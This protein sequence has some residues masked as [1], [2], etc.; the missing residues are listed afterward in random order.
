MRRWGIDRAMSRPVHS[1]STVNGGAGSGPRAPASAGSVT[2]TREL[3]CESWSGYFDA[4]GRELLSAPVS[5]EIVG[6]PGP[7][8]L[9]ASSLAL[10]ALTADCR[11]RSRSRHAVP[12][13]PG[14]LRHTVEHPQCVCMD[15][16]T[17]LASF[18]IAVDGLDD[19]RTVIA[20]EH[21]PEAGS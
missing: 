11:S 15:S 13:L 18:T 8:I 4:V 19:V 3:A 17:M 14:V 12:H 1:I 5:I 20:I 2:G 9:Q 6:A 7:P 21:E 10:L 16:Q